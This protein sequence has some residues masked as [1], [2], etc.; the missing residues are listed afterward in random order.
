M[1]VDIVA[2]AAGRIFGNARILKGRRTIDLFFFHAHGDDPRI[3]SGAINRPW[4]CD[5]FAGAGQAAA[6]ATGGNHRVKHA[7]I[8]VEDDIFD[9]AHF[10]ATRSSDFRADQLAGLNCRGAG[11]AGGRG[12]LGLRRQGSNGQTQEDQGCSD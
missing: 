10:I 2:V 6:G 8:L 7:T 5:R 12:T 1:R 9:F 11:A 4:N 3:R